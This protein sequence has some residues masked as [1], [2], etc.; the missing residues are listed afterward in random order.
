M[1]QVTW[2]QEMVGSDNGDTSILFL[3]LQLSPSNYSISTVRV[4]CNPYLQVGTNHRS[5]TRLSEPVD[6]DV[7]RLSNHDRG[8]QLPGIRPQLEA[9]TPEPVRIA[10]LRFWWCESYDHEQSNLRALAPRRIVGS[11]SRPRAYL[12]ICPKSL[13]N[14][15]IP[16]LFRHRWDT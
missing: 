16:N 4:S 5:V 1:A 14:H 6:V 15:L 10:N 2:V 3:V 13:Q 9:E 12:T 7:K 11:S 8:H